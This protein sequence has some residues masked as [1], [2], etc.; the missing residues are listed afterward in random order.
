MKTEI[1]RIDQTDFDPKVLMPAAKA[2]AEGRLVAFPT[3]TVYGLGAD[4]RNPEAASNI[5]KA[6]GRPSDNPLIVHISDMKQLDI[7][8]SAVPEKARLLMETFWPGPLTLI[9]PKAKG[10]PDETTAGLTTVAVR[11]PKNRIALELIRL[12][13][14]AVA[15]PSANL[16]GKPS[17]TCAEHVIADLS[18]RIDYIIDGGSTTVGLESTVLDMTVDTPTVLRP[19]GIS[20]EMLE[21]VIGK[22]NVDKVLA[23]SGNVVPKAPG[24]K[25]KHYAP[26]AD[27]FLVSGDTERVVNTINELAAQNRLQNK[28][29]GVLASLETQSRYAADVV[30]CAGSRKNPETVAASIFKCLRE[31]DRNGVDIIYSETFQEEGIGLAIMNRLKKAAAGRIIQ[32]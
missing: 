3:E 12:S 2:L 20:V 6:K 26:K 8:V 21:S 31:F 14:V 13:G 16:S 28:K 5:Y 23:R 10:M 4:A 25:Y 19:G 17:P 29:T 1:I 30:L 11:M 24:M 22:V 27:M 9:L 15:A 32:A 7:V 18:G